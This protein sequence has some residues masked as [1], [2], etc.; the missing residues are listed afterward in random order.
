MK[1][2]LSSQG[3]NCCLFTNNKESQS[4]G[5][6]TAQSV[7]GRADDLHLTGGV[8]GG[9]VEAVSQGHPV[10]QPSGGQELVVVLRLLAFPGDGPV[11]GVRGRE[12]PHSTHQ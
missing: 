10:A 2:F 9:H 7:T 4:V 6:A 12:A 1:S 11:D 5:A 8:V 3:G